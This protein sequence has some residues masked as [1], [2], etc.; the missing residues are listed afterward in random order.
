MIQKDSFHIVVM[1][2]TSA[3]LDLIQKVSAIIR[4]PEHQIK[5]QMAGKFLRI[6]GH[7]STESKAVES[8][9]LLVKLGVQAFRISENE[10]R[11]QSDGSFAAHTLEIRQV[12]LTFYNKAGKQK[13][14]EESDVFLIIA[15]KCSHTETLTHI[16]HKMSLNLMSTIL[17][18]GLP[19]FKK[20]DVKQETTT[21]LSEQ[22][23]QLYGGQS[24][25]PLLVIRQKDFDYSFLGQQKA[26]ISTANIS[27]TITKLREHYCH[28]LFDDRLMFPF[29]YD[30][31]ATQLRL[32]WHYYREFN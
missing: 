19:I 6:I 7:C 5:L 24:D 4:Q 12:N 3:S 26:A 25:E 31:I 28:S 10:L 27:L 11:R 17:S 32:L 16:E 22:F 8:V 20:E 18:G 21:N 23:I 14:I 9:G 13:T 29:S 30:D 15:G 2:P 1:P